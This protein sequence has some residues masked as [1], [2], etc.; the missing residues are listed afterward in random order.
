MAGIII[1]D[2]I[3]M[4][5]AKSRERLLSVMK[6]YTAMDKIHTNVVD[7]TKLHLMEI[8]RK[9][10]RDKVKIRDNIFECSMV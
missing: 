1:I 10:T 4:E 9:K 8:T 6:E 2:F 3:D 5:M 7:F